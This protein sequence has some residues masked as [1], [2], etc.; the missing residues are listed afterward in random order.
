MALLGAYANRMYEGQQIGELEVGMGATEMMYSDRHAYTVQKI[1]SDKRIIVTRDKAVRIDNNGASD[2]QEYEFESTPLVE[3]K[4]EKMCCHP[5]KFLLKDGQ[6]TCKHLD[7]GN[8]CE[9][10]EHW[11]FHK[12]TNGIT[13][14][15]TKNGWKAAGS[16]TYF[17]VGARE[18]FYDYSF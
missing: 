6:C 11:K 1:V 16:D 14:V 15:L 8:T 3:G 17:L 10:C 7:A 5:Y 18:E 9:T 13:L 12:P 4:R 2:I